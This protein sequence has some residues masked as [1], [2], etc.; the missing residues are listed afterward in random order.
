MLS[1]NSL[2]SRSG[3]VGEERTGVGSGTSCIFGAFGKYAIYEDAGR[4]ERFCSD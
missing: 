1:E 2:P 4:G 3:R